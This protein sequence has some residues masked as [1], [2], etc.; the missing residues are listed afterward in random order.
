MTITGK[1]RSLGR[2]RGVR[3]ALSLPE[4]TVRS[5]TA[6][7]AGLVRETAGVVLPIGVRRGR[8]YRSL[9]DA[10]LQFLIERVG[11][12]DAAHATDRDLGE[13][14]LL[15][16]AAGNG[17]E[18]MGILAF[19]ASPVWVLAALAD[20][21]GLGRHLIPQIAEVLKK[22]GLLEATGSFTTMDQLLEGLEGSAAQ[23]AETVNAPP[24][25]VAG[26]RREWAKLVTEV[27]R[28]PAP[29]LPSRASIVQIWD[30]LR[31]EA[32]AQHRTVFELSSLL[33]VSAVSELPERARVLSKSAA[34]ALRR[35]GAVVSDALLAH[36]RDSLAEIRSVGFSSY[37]ARQLAPYA[38][39]AVAAFH[40]ARATLTGKFIGHFDQ[41][42]E[43][44]RP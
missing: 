38:R 23:L 9:V 25:D 16:R 41:W 4:R 18:L 8:V 2:S 30:D 10:T 37:G 24:L 42:S 6:L 11:E 32:R 40:P 39:A 3:Y 17:I 22:E 36:Y 5:V 26:L 31:A 33:A 34:V 35:S 15:R 19:R 7:A 27:R 12:V 21:C 13:N 20:L 14:F 29:Q 43:R 1:L 28:L 44:R